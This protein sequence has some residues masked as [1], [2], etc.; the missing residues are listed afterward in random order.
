MR[1]RWLFRLHQKSFLTA[2]EPREI[3]NFC[4][5]NNRHFPISIR[6][7]ALSSLKHIQIERQQD[8]SIRFSMLMNFSHKSS[9][10]ALT[11]GG[12]NE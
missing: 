9:S 11:G 6:S 5:K 7:F 2:P 8:F 4:N 1:P 12:W 10:E 3:Y